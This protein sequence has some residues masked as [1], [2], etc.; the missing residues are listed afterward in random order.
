[1]REIRLYAVADDKWSLLNVKKLSEGQTGEEIINNT[2]GCVTD[3]PGGEG[4][5]KKWW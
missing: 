3:N 1:M 2:R 4:V 5:V